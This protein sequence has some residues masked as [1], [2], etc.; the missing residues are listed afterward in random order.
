MGDL[1]RGENSDLIIQSDRNLARELN[2]V[3]GVDG[4][5]YNSEQLRKLA[6][7]YKSACAIG[8]GVG[9]TIGTTAAV[10]TTLGLATPLTLPAG[11]GLGCAVGVGIRALTIGSDVV[12]MQLDKFRNSLFDSK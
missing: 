7:D 1:V 6:K 8:A 12:G 4:W 10:A 11:A 5:K 2:Q 9:A 3:P